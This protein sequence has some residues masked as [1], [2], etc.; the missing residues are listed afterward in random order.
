MVGVGEVN[1]R[2]EITFPIVLRSRSGDAY[3]FPAV[4]DTG[5]NGTLTLPQV[6][7][8]ALALEPEGEGTV[9]LGDGSERTLPVYM[10]TVVWFGKDVAVKALLAEGV[11]LIGQ[12]MTQG[13]FVTHHAVD[14]GA[15]TLYRPK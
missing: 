7:I 12:R 4:L 2:G 1:F 5:F 13:C 6:V 10:V 15:V 14:G 3:D 11:P 9:T 8:D